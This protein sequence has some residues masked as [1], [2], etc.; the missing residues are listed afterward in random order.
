M[1]ARGLRAELRRASPKP[2]CVRYLPLDLDHYERVGAERDT[3]LIV[4]C[5]GCH[6]WHHNHIRAGAGNEPS[7]RELVRLVLKP[8]GISEEK[9]VDDVLFLATLEHR[10]AAWR[11]GSKTALLRPITA[12]PDTPALM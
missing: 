9:Q 10:L 3:D 6:E 5:R 11:S 12:D 2:A 8:F 7:P 1:S 4:L